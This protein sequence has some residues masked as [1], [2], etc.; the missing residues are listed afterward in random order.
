MQKPPKSPRDATVAA[1]IDRVLAAERACEQAIAHAEQEAADRLEQAR[2]F[3]RDLLD[4]TQAR[5]TRLH[6]RVADELEDTD[7]EARR[8]IAEMNR[9]ASADLREDCIDAAIASLARSL[10]G[11][12]ASSRDA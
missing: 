10:T 5:I 12:A 6:A 7:E 1:A 11:N 3:R 8:Q 4:R 9:Q 2:E